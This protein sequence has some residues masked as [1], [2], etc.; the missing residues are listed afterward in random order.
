MRA[1]GHPQ[2]AWTGL[3]GFYAIANG[4]EILYPHRVNDETGSSLLGVLADAIPGDFRPILKDGTERPEMELMLPAAT[5]WV[6]AR[7][8]A[9]DVAGAAPH[10]R[11]GQCAVLDAPAHDA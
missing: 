5:A 7:L 11:R 10:S 4:I 3:C 2:G 9:P 8:A 6:A 1:A